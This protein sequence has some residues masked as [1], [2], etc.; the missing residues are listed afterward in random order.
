MKWVTLTP[1]EFI[2]KNKKVAALNY[3]FLCRE[4]ILFNADGTER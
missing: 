2:K 4:Q 1:S 3:S